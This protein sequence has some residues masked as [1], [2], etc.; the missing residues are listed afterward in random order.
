MLKGDNTATCKVSGINDS[1][2]EKMKAYLQG[3]VYCWC[4][5]RGEEPFCAYDFLGG[6]NNDWKGTPLNELYQHYLACGKDHEYA[7]DQAAKAASRILKQVLS[8]DARHFGTEK[9]FQSRLYWWM[10]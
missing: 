3:A 8:E 5:T 9:R 4:N 6:D 10:K 1:A 2:L 7:Y